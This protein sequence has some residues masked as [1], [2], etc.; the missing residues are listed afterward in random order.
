MTSVF[1]PWEGIAGVVIATGFGEGVRLALRKAERSGTLASR[2]D[3][4]G[5]VPLLPTAL[6]VGVP[7]TSLEGTFRSLFE[8]AIEAVLTREVDG[9]DSERRRSS[10]RGL[11][12]GTC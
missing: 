6:L 9:T 4:L 5:L 11:P 2:D 3:V 8:E 1:C 12:S 10:D 7:F